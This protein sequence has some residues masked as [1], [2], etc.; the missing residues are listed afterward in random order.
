MCA[1]LLWCTVYGSIVVKTCK[2]YGLILTNLQFLI[3]VPYIARWMLPW[4]TVRSLPFPFAW[5][6]DYVKNGLW[7][8]ITDMKLKSSLE[9]Q[10]SG[11]LMH[12][13]LVRVV[14][15]R[16]KVLPF[17]RYVTQRQRFRTN[18]QFYEMMHWFDPYLYFFSSWA[19]DE[20]AF[21]PIR[22]YFV[23]STVIFLVN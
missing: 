11:N 7:K 2:G 9:L 8:K 1:S 18:S 5:I 17:L 19:S 13:G 12:T 4:A 22:V 20:V 16:E 3:N 14:K 10:V 23:I 6:R 21:V 15:W